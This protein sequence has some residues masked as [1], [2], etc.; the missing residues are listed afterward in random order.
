MNK[1]EYSHSEN[2]FGMNYNVFYPDNY[3]DLPLIVYLHGA[4]ER[5]EHISHIYLHAIPKL[6]AEGKEY[7]AVILCPQCPAFSVWDNVVDRLKG[8]IDSV[9]E[10]FNIKKDR[11]AITGSSMGGFGTW[12]MGVTY[13]TFF[14]GI[15]PIAGGGMSW[16][17]S[18]L[19]TTP[20]YALHGKE[21]TV[22][23]IEYSRLMVEGVINGGGQAR[24][25]ELDGW[26]HNDGINYAYSETDVIDWLIKQRRTNFDYV[27][28]ICEDMFW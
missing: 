1:K 3:E 14:S 23:P 21:D 10:E 13:P 25:A 22:V 28:E 5:G 24:L 9:V 8:I 4:G 12:M 26:G 27:S 16:R 2:E 7:P 19:K 20:V 6:L 11:I 15:A 18:K 17:A